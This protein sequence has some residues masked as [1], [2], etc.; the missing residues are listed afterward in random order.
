MNIKFEQGNG[1]DNLQDIMGEHKAAITLLL[2][3][4][5]VLACQNDLCY[6]ALNVRKLST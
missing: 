2:I 4:P 5:C 6:V 1:R 3:I